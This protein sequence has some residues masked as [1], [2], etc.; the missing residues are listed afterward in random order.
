MGCAYVKERYAPHP[1]SAD[2]SLTVRGDSIG[3]FLCITA[4]TITVIRNNDDGTTTTIVAALPVSA[5][6]YYPIPFYLGKNGGSV[7][8]AGG[9]SGVVGI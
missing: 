6:V 4:G 9:A 2:G 7:T 8:L 5:G 3:G 1:V